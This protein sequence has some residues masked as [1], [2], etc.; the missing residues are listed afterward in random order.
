MGFSDYLTFCLRKDKKLKLN[1][2]QW[3]SKLILKNSYK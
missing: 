2:F 3:G 1:L